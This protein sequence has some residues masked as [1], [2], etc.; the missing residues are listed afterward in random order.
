MVGL[1]TVGQT[2]TLPDGDSFRFENRYRAPLERTLL[3]D[4]SLG[5]EVPGEADEPRGGADSVEYAFKNKIGEHFSV[6]LDDVKDLAT[7]TAW[8]VPGRE[9]LGTITFRRRSAAEL[10]AAGASQAEAWVQVASSG[11]FDQLSLLPSGDEVLE[12]NVGGQIVHMTQTNPG[13]ADALPMV[14]IS[15][16]EGA[17]VVSLTGKGHSNETAGVGVS[18]QQEMAKRS[19]RE[20]SG[21]A[22]LVGLPEWVDPALRHQRFTGASQF[23]IDRQ[24]ALPVREQ[25][26]AN[27]LLDIRDPN[28]EAAAQLATELAEALE[29]PTATKE[30]IEGLWRQVEPGV[31]RF[32]V[33]KQFNYNEMSVHRANASVEQS[34]APAFRFY[35]DLEAQ[36]RAWGIEDKAKDREPT[37]T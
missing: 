21:E 4:G 14:T 18:V 34:Q 30:K 15:D 25:R 33:I 13:R 7:L 35:N 23:E 5:P 6:E 22:V 9:A 3:P 29:A 20:L 16:E 2:H 19:A 26:R 8:E 1:V 12:L 32:E 37:T 27:S 17:R 36:L 28:A 10:E 24:N 31:Q 11:A